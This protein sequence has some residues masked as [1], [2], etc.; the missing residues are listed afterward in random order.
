MTHHPMWQAP[1]NGENP[2]EPEEIQGLPCEHG[3]R[4]SQMSALF[5]EAHESDCP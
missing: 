2:T 1:G 5:P 4:L 3:A